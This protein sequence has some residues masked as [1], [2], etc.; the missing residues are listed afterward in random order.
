MLPGGLCTFIRLSLK[1]LRT[2]Y[3]NQ[4]EPDIQ[5][6]FAFTSVA[7]YAGSSFSF[8]GDHCRLSVWF[9]LFTQSRG[10]PPRAALSGGGL[11]Q[12]QRSAHP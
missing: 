2:M 5:T 6:V 7:G 3:V 1:L 10:W 12:T 11:A 4:A 8:Q 9:L